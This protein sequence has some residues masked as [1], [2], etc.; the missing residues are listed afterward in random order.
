MKI[1]KWNKIKS[2]TL[3][4][5]RGISFENIVSHINAGHLVDI[6]EHPDKK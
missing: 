3:Q 6:I 1:Y 4:R 2:E 5:E